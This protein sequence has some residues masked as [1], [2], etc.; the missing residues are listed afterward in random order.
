MEKFYTKRKLDDRQLFAI[1][2]E[3]WKRKARE[4]REEIAR[5]EKY[6]GMRN[7]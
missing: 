7:A 3:Y 1:R 5:L 6:E 2:R 4:E